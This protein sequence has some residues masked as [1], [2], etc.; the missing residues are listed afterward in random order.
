MNEDRNGGMDDGAPIVE[1][2]REPIDQPVDDITGE[3]EHEPLP[4][5]DIDGDVIRDVDI[6]DPA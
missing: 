2:E 1:L 4:A 6:D 3:V 5:E